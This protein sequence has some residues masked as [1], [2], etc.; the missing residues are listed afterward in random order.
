MTEIEKKKEIAEEKAQKEV[1]K[2]RQQGWMDEP[3]A[4]KL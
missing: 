4:Q 2:E 1:E 3:E